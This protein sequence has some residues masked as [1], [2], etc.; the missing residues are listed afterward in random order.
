METDSLQATTKQRVLIFPAQTPKILD[1]PVYFLFS[2]VQMEDVIMDAAVHSVPF[3]PPYIEGVAEWRDHVVPVLSLEGC[4]GLKPKKSQKARRLMVVRAAKK[5]ITKVE[6]H[7]S[8]LRVVP[9]IRMATLPI[10]CT[11][12]SDGWIPQRNLVRGIYEWE[13]GFLV[14]THTEKILSGGNGI[15]SEYAQIS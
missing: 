3:S 13:K 5:E 10:E 6:N 7:R 2:L 15:G 4:L 1:K 14:V 12:V 11:P 9:P 8:M